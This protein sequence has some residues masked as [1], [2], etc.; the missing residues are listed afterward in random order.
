M[1]CVHSLEHIESLLSSYLSDNDSVGTHSK[2]CLN[3]VTDGY[4]VGFLGVGFS[5]LK[6]H[7]VGNISYLELRRILYCNYSFP[8]RDEVGQ[9]VKECGLTASGSSGNKDVVAGD[10]KLS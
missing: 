1:S 5:G 3:Q 10:N 8:L 4:F 2:A 7:K 9:R 6:A